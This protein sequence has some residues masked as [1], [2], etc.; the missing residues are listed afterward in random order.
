M[1]ILHVLYQYSSQ[2]RVTK[3]EMINV[4]EFKVWFA[5]SLQFGKII[6]QLIYKCFLCSFPPTTQNTGND[7]LFCNRQFNHSNVVRIQDEKVSGIRSP[8]GFLLLENWIFVRMCKPCI[9][10]KDKING[11]LVQDCARQFSIF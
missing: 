11:L 5:K 9:F 8:R 1:P 10:R 6:Q 3:E 7:N 4:F 2:T